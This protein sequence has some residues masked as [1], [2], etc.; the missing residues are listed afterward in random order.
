VGGNGGN[1]DGGGI[2]LARGVASID[3]CLIV[4]NLAAGGFAGAGG[5]D[6]QGVGG[7]LWV[8]PSA[9]A[10]GSHTGIIGNLAT[11]SNDDVFGTFTPS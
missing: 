7:G 4:G 9:T 10:G 8:A 3:R 6:G 1:G 5:H 2:Y 11:T